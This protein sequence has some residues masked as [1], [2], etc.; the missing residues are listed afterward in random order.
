MGM[1]E[2]IALADPSPDEHPLGLAG[3]VYDQIVDMILSEQLIPLQPLRTHSLAS[4]LGVS[5]TPVR[6]ALVRAT[7]VGLVSRVNNKGFRVAPR[8]TAAELD[9]LFVARTAIERSTAALAAIHCNDEL[10]AGL[11]DSWQFQR[12]L[13]TDESYAGFRGFLDG[14]SRFHRLIAQ[15]SGNRFLRIAWETF[16][17]HVQRY[18]SF[19]QAVVTDRAETLVEHRAIIEA[20]RNKNQDAAQAA[21]TLHLANLRLRVHR[22]RLGTGEKNSI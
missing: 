16:G 17:S 7:A 22:E 20:I 13:N 2:L 19:D 21:M 11:E 1:A 6:E 3:H 8:P 14:D 10:L 4:S 15:A 5:A 18:R 12:N 9:D